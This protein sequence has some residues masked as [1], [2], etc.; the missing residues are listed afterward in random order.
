MSANEPSNP[1]A[2]QRSSDTAAQAALDD[3]V[4]ES[5]PASDPPSMTD[6]AHGVSRSDDASGTD[7]GESDLFQP[8]RMGPLTLAN[9]IVMAPLT[10]S[11]AGKG[12]VPRELNATYYAQRA[13][14][15]L[16]ISEATQ[17]TQQGKGYA[18]T[19]GIYSEEQVA[20]WR[21]V[22]DAVHTRGGHI[23]CQLWHVGRISHPD[24]QP[25]SGLPVAPSAIKPEGQAFTETGFKPHVTPRAL[26]TDEV[27]GIV[28]DYAHAAECARRAGFDGVEIHAANGYLIDQFLRDSTNKRTDRYGGSVENRTRFALEVV[29]A[30]TSAWGGGERVGIRLSP[31]TPQVGNTPLDSDPMGTYGYLIDRLNHFGLVYL[32]CIRGR[33]T[34]IAGGA[35]GLQLPAAAA[36]VPGAVH[37]Q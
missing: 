16:I 23:V 7:A 36:H 9:R 31:L 5:F 35:A 6:P 17:I 8:V 22:T 37:G 26:D 3:A 28:R 10:R 15:G 24:L 14:A 11:R 4:A 21:L 30:V 25:W 18:F 19:P 34:G 29:A 12:D 13:T 27:P 20:G 1:T 32:H 33:D 2:G